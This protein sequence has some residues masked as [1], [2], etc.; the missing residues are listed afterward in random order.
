MRRPR[1]PLVATGLAVAV[2]AWHCAVLLAQRPLFELNFRLDTGLLPVT[3]ALACAVVGPRPWGPFA[4]GFLAAGFVAAAAYVGVCRTWP[5]FVAG[6][7]LSY[8][9]EV[10]PRFMDADTLPLY[11]L[12]LWV[13]GLITGLPLCLVALAGGLLAR[14]A[15]R[16]RAS[17]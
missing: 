11:T 15:A 2:V 6:P 14:H 3:T 10:E 7:V 5:D 4:G 9:N 16:R 17:V 13:R 1:V 12:S 8:V